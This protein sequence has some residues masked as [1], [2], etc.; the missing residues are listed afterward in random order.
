VNFDLSIVIP[1]Y[2]EEANI[3]TLFER[4]TVALQPAQLK[5]VQLIF[6]DDGSADSTMEKVR[7][8]PTEKDGIRVDFIELS[9]NFGHQ[10]AVT[11]G[12]DHAAG[13]HVAIIDADLQ[14]PPELIPELLNK[15]NEGFDVVYAKR[16]ARKGESLA[17]KA[18]A[19]WFYRVLSNITSVDI[20]MDTGDFRVISKRV[21]EV[22]KQMPEQEKFLRGQIAWVGFN[23]TYVEFDREERQ[24]GETGYTW[25]KM[26]SLAL[27]GITSFSDLP[28]KVAT[29]SGFFMSFVSFLLMLYALYS[30]FI[31]KV[32]EPGWTS[33][34]LSILFIGGIQLV[35]IGIIGEYI[36]RI[37]NN[38]RQRPLYIIKD[39]TNIES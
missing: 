29:V 36:G 12:L 30:R 28:L 22:L 1:V 35:A 37:G 6:V 21:V 13:N 23:Q 11:A 2:N 31:L 9:R 19:K 33:L 5:S 15:A 3:A 8:L 25:R 4:L 27:D 38:V 14:D 16:R 32:Y 34:M 10:I 26:I 20:P 39:K 17:K 24:A 18:T 7:A